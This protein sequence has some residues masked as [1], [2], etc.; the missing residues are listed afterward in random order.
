MNLNKN[1]TKTLYDKIADVL[2]FELKSS[3]QATDGT[4][5]STNACFCTIIKRLTVNAIQGIIIDDDTAASITLFHELSYTGAT[6]L[7]CADF[8]HRVREK[9]A[10]LRGVL[11]R[12]SKTTRPNI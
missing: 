2:G 5:C 6:M 10:E 12:E 9:E 7:D 11:E 1:E 8:V 4:P 3:C